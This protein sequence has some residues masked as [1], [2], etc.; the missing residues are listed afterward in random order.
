MVCRL[1]A[2]VLIVLL[3]PPLWAQYASPHAGQPS[4]AI[5]MMGESGPLQLHYL[6]SVPVT[7]Q[8]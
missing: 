3:T 8:Y 7:E 6:E 1:S 5:A 4:Q 2:L